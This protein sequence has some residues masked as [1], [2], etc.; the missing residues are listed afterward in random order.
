[1][2]CWP[3]SLKHYRHTNF[4]SNFITSYHDSNF[5]FINSSKMIDLFRVT[6]GLVL[7]QTII[8]WNINDIVN[9]RSKNI[10][11]LSQ[12]VAAGSFLLNYH[13]IQL[14]SY[15]ST[16]FNGVTP[17]WFNLLKKIVLANPLFS[18]H[19]KPE[20]CFETQVFDDYDTSLSIDDFQWNTGWANLW[21]PP[22]YDIYKFPTPGS[23]IF[24]KVFKFV[25]PAPPCL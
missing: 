18:N 17:R 10:L 15:S 5:S 11:F 20:Y 1:M 24:G 16:N 12:V 2:V 25:S 7:L 21:T 13:D 6:G 22:E 14:R 8:P 9:I 4:L 19:L 23:P 3:K